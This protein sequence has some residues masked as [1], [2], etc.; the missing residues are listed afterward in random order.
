M[1]AFGLSALWR[2]RV[3]GEWLLQEPVQNMVALLELFP[4]KAF[5]L[6]EASVQQRSTRS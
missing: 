1:L 4:K 6:I 5:Q 2:D 3:S